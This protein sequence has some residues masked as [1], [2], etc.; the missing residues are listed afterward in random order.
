MKTITKTLLAAG[1][2]LGLATVAVAGGS[3]GYSCSNACPLA[4]RANAMR[5][6]G[7]EA[8]KVSTFAQACLNASV[9]KN[10]SRI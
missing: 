5:S 9:E 3:D 2:V 10:L 1:L 6:Y 7:S 8:A 4:Q